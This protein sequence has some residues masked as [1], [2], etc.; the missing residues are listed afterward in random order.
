MLHTIFTIVSVICGGVL[1]LMAFSGIKFFTM[2][3]ANL[4]DS[5]NLKII[6][7]FV[8]TVLITCLTMLFF[9]V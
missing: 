3:T 5:R 1:Y 9:V 4:R 2:V 8:L 6:S 7:T